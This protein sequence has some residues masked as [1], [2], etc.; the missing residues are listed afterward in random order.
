MRLILFRHGPAEDPDPE[1]WP[2]DLARPLT[3]RGGN[4]SRDAAHGLARLEPGIGKVFSSPA[5][6]ALA[7]ARLLATALGGA[8]PV[9]V[10]AALAPGGDERALLR[11]VAHEG[12]EATVAIVGHEPDLAQLAAALLGMRTEALHFKKAGACA[13]EWNAPGL[14]DARLRGWLAPSAL[15]AFRPRRKGQAA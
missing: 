8:V 13:I 12:P 15:R 9:E 14:G 2:D 7:T 1:R 6:R 5:V 3:A 4:R 11:A 10:L